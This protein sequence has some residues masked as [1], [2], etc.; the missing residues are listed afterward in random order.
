MK[1]I[2][3]VYQQKLHVTNKQVIKKKHTYDQMSYKIFVL[4]IFI[5][6]DYIK[7]NFVLIENK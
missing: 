4:I 1:M 2:A 5:Y 3:T 6:L 7:I